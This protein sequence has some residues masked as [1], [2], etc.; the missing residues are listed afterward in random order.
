MTDSKIAFIGLGLIGGSI[1]RGLKRSCPETIIMAYM[2]TRSR[3]EQAKKDGCI[4]HEDGDITQGKERF[5]EFYDTTKSGKA[6]KVRLADYYS[7]DDPSGYDPES[8]EALK[9]GYPRLYVLDLSFDGEQYTIRW[10]ED[11]EEII[12]NYPYLLK[13]EGP[14]ES[15]DA[16]YKSYTRYVLTNDDGVTWQELVWGM[17]S[18]QLGDYIDHMSI[19]T[20]YV[21]E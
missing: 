15:S 6:D 9:A 10:Y 2:R 16:V 8:Y 12:R 21:Y 13:Y 18:S 19:C 1:A 11:G 7:P 17:I 5:E 20:D 4:T 3:L 14:A